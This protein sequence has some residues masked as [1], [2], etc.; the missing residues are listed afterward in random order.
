V[1]SCHVERPLHDRVWAAFTQLQERR[2]GGFAIAALI[3]PPDAAA[4]EDDDERWPIRAREAHDRGPLGH[5]THFTSPT[6]ARPTG[7]DTGE[8][9][10]REGAWLRE[11][12]LVPTVYCGGGWYTDRSVAVACAEL[13]YA[14]CTP[15]A[16]R[17][18][19][20]PEGAAWAKL[21][22]PARIDL[23]DGLVLPAVPTTHG[24][25]DLTRGIARAG[26]PPRVHA[27][28]HDTDL[29]NP[30][31]RRL[32]VTTLSVLGRLRPP[33]DLD[34]LAGVVRNRAPRVPWNAVAQGEAAEA[35]T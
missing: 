2:P 34:T 4:R 23:D 13:R 1:V 18:G 35:R 29:V 31:R 15:R 28:F 5:H 3:R 19:Y 9:V 22:V 7:G 14:D 24:I 17:P 10:R 21:A 8:R 6:H 16:T 20:L 25:G 30:A 12:G 11:R 26:P 32:I 27:Y 33:T